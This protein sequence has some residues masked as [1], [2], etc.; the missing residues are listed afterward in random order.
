MAAAMNGSLLYLPR[1]ES[2]DDIRAAGKSCAENESLLAGE[3]GSLSPLSFHHEL[4]KLGCGNV[5]IEI[6]LRNKSRDLAE[7]YLVSASTLGFAGA[8]IATGA[9]E[10]RA[11]MPMPVYDL[12]A[13]QALMLA[14]GLKKRG[15]LRANFK[16]GVRAAS[17]SEAAQAR[18]RH[19]VI[20]GADFIVMPHGEMVQGLEESTVLLR[21]MKPFK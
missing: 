15:T 21:E 1:I 19:F 10:K 6:M 18:A 20:A 7:S 13:T 4:S 8:V 16:I 17:G 9:F 12:D 11:N 2:V 5:L 3:Y 14:V